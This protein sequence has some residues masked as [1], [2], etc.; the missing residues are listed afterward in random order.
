M[1]SGQVYWITGLSGAGKTTVGRLLY[2]HLLAQKSNVV[3]LDGDILREVFGSD[4]G[5]SKEERL[6]SAYRNARLCRLLSDQGI[7]VVC[8]TISLFHEIQQWNRK[9]I[10]GYKEIFLDV[11]LDILARRGKKHVYEETA[12]NHSVVGINIQ[13]EKPLNP[14]LTVINDGSRSP[15]EIALILIDTFLLKR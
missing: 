15:Q 11:P 9:H 13:E 5:Y 6:R 8:A 10:P 3:F 1:H 4:L 7:D 12:E 14:D 2:E